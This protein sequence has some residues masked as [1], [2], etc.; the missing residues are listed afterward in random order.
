MGV[1]VDGHARVERS[2]EMKYVDQIHYCDVQVPSDTLDVNKLAQLREN[3]HRRHEELYTYSEPDNEPEIVSLRTSIVVDT[4]APTDAGRD[5]T[6]PEISLKPQDTRNVIMPDSQ[7]FRA[8]PVYRNIG[9][10][11][12]DR[13]K[14]VPFSIQGPAI[15]EE[16][17]TTIFVPIGDNIQYNPAGFYLLEVDN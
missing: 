17:T 16:E 6:M 10:A 7:E 9:H 8:T 12:G 11:T 3:F 14:S 1:G 13:F 5:A 15:I 4:H 2:A